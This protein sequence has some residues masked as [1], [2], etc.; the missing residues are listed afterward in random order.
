MI[1][2]PGYEKT[3]QVH[4][5]A[6]LFAKTLETKLFIH[7]VNKPVNPGFKRYMKLWDE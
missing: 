1:A 4:P 6:G 2:T 7:C 3:I 5:L